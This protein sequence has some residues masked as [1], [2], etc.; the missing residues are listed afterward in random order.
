[1]AIEDT[2]L[3]KYGA[4]SRPEDD[5]ST[6]GGAVDTSCVLEIDQLAASDQVRVRSSDAGDSMD[7]TL[8]YR[9]DAGEIVTDT[10]SLNGTTNV[11]FTDTLERLLKASLAS[12]P[13][14]DVT[15]ERNTGG[16]D[17]VVVIPAGK[18]DATI[19][20][21]DASSDAEETIRYEKE[22]WRNEHGTLTLTN[23]SIEL[24]QDPSS[25]IR[26]G[27]AASLNDSDDVTDRMTAPGGISF[28]DDSVLVDVPGGALPA[29]DGI[30]VWIEMTRGADAAAL[31][32]SYTTQI[33]GT[34]T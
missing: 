15:I 10:E 23:A 32:S 31:K 9:N 18:T 6:S 11:V 30:G 27:V 17:Q 33:A 12:S 2:D 8:T 5:E 20:F 16:N 4:S 14:G 26:I 34:S 22:F 1:M 13:T 3:K 28:V 21:I 7:L 25:S 29:G 19:L 24:T